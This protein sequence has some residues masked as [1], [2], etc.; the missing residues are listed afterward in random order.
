[1]KRFMRRGARVLLLLGITWIVFVMV[2][3]R[4]QDRLIFPRWLA[5]GRARS[6]PPPEV[7]VWTTP[8]G[9]TDRVEA[10]FIAAEGDHSTAPAIVLTHGN[11]ELIDD[12]VPVAKDWSQLGYHVLLPEYR[13][14]GRC[15]DTPSEAGIVQDVCHFIDRLKSRPDVDADRIAMIGRSIGCGVACQVALSHDPMAM[16]LVVPPARIDSIAWSYGFPPFLVDHPFRS[17]LA[18]PE[19]DAP[20]LI[21]Q[22]D[23]DE[24]IPDHHADV[25]HE[26]ASN[27]HLLRV[28]GSHNVAATPEAEQDAMRGFLNLHLS[29]V[30]P[31]LED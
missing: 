18:L 1:M 28:Q 4:V 15:G 23:R 22:R 14:Y 27:S 13:G 3:W 12:L 10:W 31:I 16:I 17:D 30:H 25:L 11:A 19:I 6:T 2:A 20:V 24:V 7:D 9:G 8:V 5:N 21:I 29:P 26:A